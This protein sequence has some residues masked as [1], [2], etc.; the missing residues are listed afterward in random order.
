MEL[1]KFVQSPFFNQR[2]DLTQLY[3]YLQDCLT[4]HRVIPTKK[5]A[6]RH[7]YGDEAYNDHR[8]RVAMSLLSKLAEKFLFTQEVLS[9]EIAMKTKLLSIYRQRQLRKHFKYTLRDA[10]ALQEKSPYRN[11]DYH[12]HQFTL[13]LESYQFKAPRQ[14]ISDLNLQKAIGYLDTVYISRKLR[15]I[16]LALSH[17]AVYRTEYDLGLI[18]ALLEHIKNQRLLT[19]P[20]ISIY[21]YA[22]HAISNP[23]ETTHFNA[24]KEILLDAA[25]LFPLEEQRDLFLLA[26]NFCMRSYNEGNPLYLNDLLEL[27]QEGLE[28]RYLFTNG[29]LSHFTFRNIVTLGLILKEYEWVER[30]IHNYCMHLSSEYRNGIFSFC[31]ARLEYSRRNYSEA[32]ALLQQSEYK[33]LLLNLS[34]KTVMLKIYYETGEFNLLDSHLQAMQIFLRRKKVMAYHQENY[35]NLLRFTK[36]LLEIKPYDKAA[37]AMI[38]QQ[39]EEAKAIAERVWLLEQLADI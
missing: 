35:L 4:V 14:R 6:F 21:Y 22:Y 23:N 12:E 18:E 36:K 9:D 31:L 1:D 5:Q 10:E 7:L 28:Q 39:I 30:F 17:Q 8:V 11:A 16:C 32:L 2:E 38:K 25:P 3:H 34:A 29:V 13:R 19:I 27:Y 33:D 20:A 26:I 15:Q 24:F 37:K